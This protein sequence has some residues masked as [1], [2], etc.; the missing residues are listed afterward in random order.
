[1]RK[2]H[3][4]LPLLLTCLLLVTGCT[5]Q[6][7]P[8]LRQAVDRKLAVQR[9]VELDCDKPTS[10]FCAVQSPL[11]YLGSIDTLENQQIVSSGLKI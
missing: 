9:S 2:I 1:M 8:G 5:T 4:S 7:Q 10:P 11:I 3:C 6:V